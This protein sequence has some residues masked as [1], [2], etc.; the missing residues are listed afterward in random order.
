MGDYIMLTYLDYTLHSLRGN[1]V[2]YV[3]TNTSLLV[4]TVTTD[5]ARKTHYKIVLESLG[6]GILDI[7]IRP[8]EIGNSLLGFKKVINYTF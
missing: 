1:S 2:L 6:H 7:P 8:M 5:M 4:K 3:N